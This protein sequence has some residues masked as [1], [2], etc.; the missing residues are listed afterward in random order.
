MDIESS[1]LA[2]L[3]DWGVAIRELLD[4]V[5]IRG[6]SKKAISQFDYKGRRVEL[7]ILMTDKEDDFLFD[8]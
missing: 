2:E 1:K 7:Q 5:S 4:D 3:I 6:E 8:D